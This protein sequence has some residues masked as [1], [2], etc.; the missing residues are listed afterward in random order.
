MGTKLFAGLLVLLIFILFAVGC[1][2]PTK[3]TIYSATEN[4]ISI[5]YHAFDV[6]PTVTA[7]AIDMAVKH[8]NKYGRGMKHVS[9]NGTGLS[10][11]EIH[12]FICTNDFTDKKIEVELK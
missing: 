10:F 12:T 2:T 5:K 3:P 11:A 4:S 7:E 8:C 1:G 6:L 9:S